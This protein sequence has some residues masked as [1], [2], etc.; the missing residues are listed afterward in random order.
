MA[1]IYLDNYGCTAN[2]DNGAIIAGL[3]VESGH[4]I[5]NDVEESDVVVINSCA[6]KNVTVNKIF[7]QI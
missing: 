4:S 7:S 1:T 2:Y 6:V 3:L 5:V